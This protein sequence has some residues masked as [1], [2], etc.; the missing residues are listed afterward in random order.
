MIGCHAKRIDEEQRIEEMERRTR[1]LIIV[2]VIALAAILIDGL[3]DVHAAKK[4]AS[5]IQAASAF[6]ACLNGYQIEIGSA[7]IACNIK[8]IKLVEGMK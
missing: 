1:P 8:E 5:Q 3:I 7:Y 4:Y 6:A 2:L